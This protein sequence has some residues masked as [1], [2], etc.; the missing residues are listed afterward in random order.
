MRKQEMGW[1]QCGGAIR[2][3]ARAH[4]GRRYEIRSCG[5]CGRVA[6]KKQVDWP[7]FVALHVH[8]ARPERN[9]EICQIGLAAVRERRVIGSWEQTVRPRR[10]ID[11][12]HTALHGIDDHATQDCPE[13]GE[14]TDTIQSRMEGLCVVGHTTM[15]RNVLIAALTRTGQSIEVARWEEL[16]QLAKSLTGIRYGASLRGLCEATG[17]AGGGT[18]SGSRA[19]TIAE[20]AIAVLEEGNESSLAE[21]LQRRE[22]AEQKNVRYDR[23]VPHEE[24]IVEIAREVERELAAGRGS[25]TYSTETMSDSFGASMA[26]VRTLEAKTGLD[27]Q[28]VVKIGALAGLIERE[29]ALSRRTAGELFAVCGPARRAWQRLVRGDR[30]R[31]TGNER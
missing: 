20:I 16:G 8:T 21:Y 31:G 3:I 22:Q 25:E 6:S 15:A 2:R 12:R 9:P 30:R 23:V 14:L 4:E 29:A 13:F 19:E 18:G 5:A 24:Q 10:G 27:I 1:C 26:Q 7:E 28:D 17:T 11:K